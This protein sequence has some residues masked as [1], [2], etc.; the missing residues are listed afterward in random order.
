MNA[1][2]HFPR[3]NNFHKLQHIVEDCRQKELKD[4]KVYEYACAN[5]L[6]LVTLNK[7]HFT[8][9]VAKNGSGIIGISGNMTP[10][11]IDNKLLAYL[12]KHSPQQL[13]GKYIQ[14]TNETSE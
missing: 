13:K 2:K 1:S 5:A 8:K 4:P 10:D 6:I 3:L 14:I 11:Q 7:K 12:K 9:I